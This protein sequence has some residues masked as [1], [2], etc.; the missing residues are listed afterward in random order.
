MTKVWTVLQDIAKSVRSARK[1]EQS[2]MAAIRNAIRDLEKILRALSIAHIAVA[3]H[4]E[5]NRPEPL[6]DPTA[7]A[8]Q[9]PFQ[10]QT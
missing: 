10:V 8:P 3:K 9:P 7:I 5:A 6:N 4:L 1:K 2:E